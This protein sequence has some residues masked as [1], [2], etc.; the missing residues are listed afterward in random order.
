VEDLGF[1]P[2]GQLACLTSHGILY[3]WN[4]EENHWSNVNIVSQRNSS[5]EVMR[6]RMIQLASGDLCI[7]F[8][9]NSE[10]ITI[11]DYTTHQKIKMIPTDLTSRLL[12]ALT[13]V[14]GGRIAVGVASARSGSNDSSVLVYS[15]ET[16]DC[17]QELNGIFSCH[18]VQ[19]SD[20]RLCSTNGQCYLT[21]W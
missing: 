18:M 2:N 14:R 16:G 10:E 9:I 3:F 4:V 1:L 19:L 5:N 15:I 8:I 6:F 21:V 17:E 12:V 20:G 11:W 13:M 7:G